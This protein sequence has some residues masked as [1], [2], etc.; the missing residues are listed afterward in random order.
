MKKVSRYAFWYNFELEFVDL[1]DKLVY[2]GDNA[3]DQCYK[4]K[5]INL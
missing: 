1:T 2:I 4:L 3:F 5:S